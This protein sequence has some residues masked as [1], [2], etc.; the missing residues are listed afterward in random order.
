MDI[1]PKTTEQ[2]PAGNKTIQKPKVTVPKT[3]TTPQ[4]QTQSK[5][6]K[7]QKQT[8]N[9]NQISKP[10]QTTNTSK[11]ST[12][13][14]KQTKPI[15]NTQTQTQMPKPTPQVV[16]QQTQIQPNINIIPPQQSEQEL[17]NFKKGIQN[18]FASKIKGNLL[19]VYGDGSCIVDFKVDSTGKFI[20]RSFS[21]Q[22]S[23]NTLNDAVYHAV[24][25]IPAYKT[26]P[27]AYKGQ[28]MHL[29][30]KITNGMVQI[31]VY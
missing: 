30:V 19:Q 15:N 5:T 4:K 20:N 12:V 28:T 26:P 27:S 10:A 7:I 1:I 23:N 8:T 22:S 9:K 14:P 11:G 18:A 2:Q 17:K 31:S 21:K 3:K 24:M 25:A 29:S 6:T 13:T 16:Q